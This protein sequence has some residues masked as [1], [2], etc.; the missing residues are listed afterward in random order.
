[1]LAAT[2][3]LWPQRCPRHLN[4]SAPVCPAVLPEVSTTMTWRR[5][6]SGS[7]ASTGR[8]RVARRDAALEL[9]QRVYPEVR[10]GICLARNRADAADGEDAM[11]ATGREPGGEGDAE[12]AGALAARHNRKCHRSPD[13]GIWI[14]PAHG[15]RRRRIGCYWSSVTDRTSISPADV[16]MNLTPET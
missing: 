2:A 11:S 14:L 9:A 16:G 7:S 3:T 10:I 4:A 13:F 6:V 12:M 8:E 5:M 15:R 1:M